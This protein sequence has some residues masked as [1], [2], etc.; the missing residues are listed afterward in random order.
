MGCWPIT[1]ITSVNVNEAA[2]LATLQAALEAGINFFDTAYAYGYEGESERLIAR[3]GVKS[4]D[5]VR[6]HPRTLIQYSPERR[7]LN[8]EL[9]TYLYRNLYFSPQVDEANTRAVRILEQVFKY[10]LS[11][12][13]ELGELSPLRHRNAC[14]EIARAHA[15][16]PVAQ[17]SQRVEQ[18]ALNA[19]H[20]QSEDAEGA[21]VLAQI[22]D[23]VFGGGV[24]FYLLQ[25]FTAGI[26]I[27]AA[28]TAYAD[29]PRLASVSVCPV[30]SG[31][32]ACETRPPNT[33]INAPMTMQGPAPNLSRP[34]G[35]RK[36]PIAAP[37]R[38]TAAAMPMPVARTSV[39]RISEG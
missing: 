3:A 5:D 16:R 14:R 1:G 23:T 24:P 4:A 28:N 31:A 2:S 26:L 30:V 21:S 29:F 38:L 25:A 13:R 37:M 11:H 35:S 12:P 15:Q 20:Q 8:L 32:M 19:H 34:I 27:L 6:L 18:L 39:G 22:G 33:Q 10:Y 7:A 9:R 17:V 36:V